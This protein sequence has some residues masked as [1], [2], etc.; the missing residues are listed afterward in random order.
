MTDHGPN[1]PETD[2]EMERIPGDIRI[3][4]LLEVLEE[5]EDSKSEPDPK[6]AAELYKYFDWKVRVEGMAPSD[7]ARATCGQALHDT[8]NLKKLGCGFA[9]K[10][11]EN[12]VG[13]VAK[14]YF[15]KID[16]YLMDNWQPHDL[17]EEWKKLM[18]FGKEN[19]NG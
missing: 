2:Y 4:D 14:V 8:E 7:A 19:D 10:F 18:E 1:V 16:E 5:A 9:R 13:P 17:N 11:I 6:F 12:V 15:D 3:C